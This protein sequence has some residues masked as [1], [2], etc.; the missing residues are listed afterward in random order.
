MLKK[1]VVM[2]F[3]GILAL[4]T[5]AQNNPVPSNKEQK[6]AAKRERINTLLRQEEEGELIF[7]KQSVFG[8]KLSTDGYG[9]TYE[10]GKFKSNRK[11]LLYQFEFSEK[12]HRK[13]KKQAA[14]FNQF[15]VNS[16]V[17]GKENNFYQFKAGL[18]MN[19]VIGGKGN[20]HGVAVSAIY[21]GGIIAG[22][23]KP[24]YVDVE[25]NFSQRVRKTYPEI[26]DSGYIEFGAAGFTVGWNEV[27]FRPGL[28][29][30]TAMRFDYGRFNE[31]VTAIEAGLMAEFYSSKI[32]QM[33]MNKQK[34]FF[35]SAYLSL[36]LGRRK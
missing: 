17:F 36:L 33:V 15:Q 8:I 21:G 12:K 27:K 32:P 4:T 1:L 14:S 18:A 7:N 28:Y 11:S 34:Q 26:I 3:T 13:E 22:L 30:K 16:V 35:F 31:T 6:K 19:K 9:L 23:V 29:A 10:L 20:K 2:V 25:D 5:I 24:Y